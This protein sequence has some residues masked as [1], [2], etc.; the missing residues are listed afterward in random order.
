M[1]TYPW[2]VW[3]AAQLL[4]IE[5][6]DLSRKLPTA[7]VQASHLHHFAIFGHRRRSEDCLLGNRT[8][9]LDQRANLLRLAIGEP[10]IVQKGLKKTIGVSAT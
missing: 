8:R 1:S 2:T 7:V 5:R 9:L 6:R 3:S 10:T 4:L